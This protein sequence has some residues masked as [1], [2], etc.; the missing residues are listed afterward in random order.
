MTY[1]QLLTRSI[2][3]NCDPT[4]I[5]NEPSL[6]QPTHDI[7]RSRRTSL[8]NH[9][10]VIPTHS[11]SSNCNKAILCNRISLGSKDR[12]LP[13]HPPRPLYLH[14]GHHSRGSFFRH[15]K[16]ALLR[17][18]GDEVEEAIERV[19]EE[20]FARRCEFCWIH[21]KKDP[22]SGARVENRE[23][24]PQLMN[25]MMVVWLFERCVLG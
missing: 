2:D 5:L 16:S 18:G 12:L 20:R 1:A 15:D 9:Q 13:R 22:R 19:A 7:K 4:P 23:V 6:L 25:D 3:H 14:L 11:P 24:V 17:Q 10:N 21:G 8:R